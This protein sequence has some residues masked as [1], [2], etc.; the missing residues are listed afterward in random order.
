MEG[1]MEGMFVVNGVDL[2]LFFGSV[3]ELVGTIVL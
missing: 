2:S 3:G 1:L